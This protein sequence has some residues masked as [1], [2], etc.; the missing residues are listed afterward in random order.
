MYVYAPAV[1]AAAPTVFMVWLR[2]WF[3]NE[4]TK[5][6]LEMEHAKTLNLKVNEDQGKDWLNMTTTAQL[7]VFIL[8]PAIAC[9]THNY[10]TH[11]AGTAVTCRH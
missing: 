7:D 5:E 1:E 4:D 10:A 3:R 8:L 9:L 6:Y 11:V 2:A